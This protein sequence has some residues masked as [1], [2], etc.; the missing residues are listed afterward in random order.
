MHILG[1][2]LKHQ[3]LIHPVVT[4]MRGPEEPLF[5]NGARVRTII[6]ISLVRRN[7]TVAFSVLSYAGSLATT[8]VA[9]AKRVPDL[10][11]LIHALQEEFAAM[12]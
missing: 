1:W 4:N 7:V 3:H 11:C 8:I 5:F 2:L 9:N 10:P 12:S 6:P